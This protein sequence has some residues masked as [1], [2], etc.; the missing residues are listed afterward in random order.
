MRRRYRTH[1]L[2]VQVSEDDGVTWKNVALAMNEDGAFTLAADAERGSL[3]R[4]T[5]QGD[6]PDGCYFEEA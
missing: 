5:M 3:T 2:W 6:M 1:G 4:A